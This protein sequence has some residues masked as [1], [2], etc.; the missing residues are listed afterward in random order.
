MP[1]KINLDTPS[2]NIIGN[3]STI[4][5]DNDYKPEKYSEFLFV[6]QSND[7]NISN[8]VWK[9]Q[10]QEIHKIILENNT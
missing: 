3:D 9:A 8:F 10:N 4:F 6:M 5:T 2:T 7:C 1:D